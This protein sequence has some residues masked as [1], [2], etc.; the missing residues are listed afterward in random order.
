MVVRTWK[1]QLHKNEVALRENNW[2]WLNICHVVDTI[3]PIYP[4]HLLT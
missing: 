1:A 3:L 4:M 2:H